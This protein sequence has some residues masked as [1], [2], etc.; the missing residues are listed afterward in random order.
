MLLSCVV[1][2]SDVGPGHPLALHPPA[3]LR[4]SSEALRGLRAPET[5]AGGSRRASSPSTLRAPLP[6]CP[7]AINWGGSV[8]F[9]DREYTVEPT[10]AAPFLDLLRLTFE[11]CCSQSSSIYQMGETFRPRYELQFSFFGSATATAA[12]AL[13]P[14][15]GR[16]GKRKKEKKEKTN[17]QLFCKSAGFPK[18]IMA[19]PLR[20]W[21]WTRPG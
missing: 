12:T 20:G 16:G 14:L 17:P 3:A 9:G 6:L 1:K 5:S 21:K 8:Y 10:A 15:R 2:A 7:V 4:P 13:W 19:L 18:G 11:L